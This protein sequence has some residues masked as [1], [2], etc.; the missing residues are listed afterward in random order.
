MPITPAANRSPDPTPTP[1]H[2]ARRRGLTLALLLAAFLAV[3]PSTVGPGSLGPAAARAAQPEPTTLNDLRRENQLLR[4]RIEALNARLEASTATIESLRAEIAELRAQITRLVE[5]AE[6][7][8]DDRP[9]APQPGD[10]QPADDRA[11]RDAPRYA[12]LPADEPFAAPPALLNAMTDAYER[13]AA[14]LSYSIDEQRSRYLRDLRD[15]A[16]SYNRQTREPVEW[17]I[18]I[19]AS[20][21]DDRSGVYEYRVLDP[22]TLLPYEQRAHELDL[23][24]RDAR[25]IDLGSGQLL[26][27]LRAVV[28]AAPIVNPQ[29][30]EPGFFNFPPFV[31]RG[32]EFGFTVNVR[33][34]TAFEP[35]GEDDGAD[36]PDGDPAD[37][38]AD[39]RGP[40]AT[41][42]FDRP[43]RGDRIAFVVDMTA[44]MRVNNRAEAVKIELARAIRALPEG[45]RFSII[46]STDEARELTNGRWL[47]ADTRTRSA[48]IASLG[49]ITPTGVGAPVAAWDA[50]LELYP[51]PDAVVAIMA[52]VMSPQ[53][54]QAV[55][56]RALALPEADER[57]PV[58]V[59]LIE[60]ERS[61]ELATSLAGR[62]G[63]SIDVIENAGP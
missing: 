22:Q 24:S 11:P 33:S 7:P 47:A 54:E 48:V 32:L 14:D 50:L 38:D 13:F 28:A 41:T 10:A 63:G 16:R 19:L 35:D 61:L 26:Y 52:G 25:N 56:D 4:E 30:T 2:A 58:H 44:A 20:P 55:I 12:P 57:I 17:I 42:V 59:L 1:R 46:V 15:W 18:E 27:T 53:E 37:A 34:I 21:D 49:Q 39:N 3:I 5:Q 45:A 23:S 62:T 51:P 60:D 36:R 31:G 9:A 8:A 29:R 43:V 6:R 40:V